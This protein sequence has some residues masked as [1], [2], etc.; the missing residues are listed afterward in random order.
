MDWIKTTWTMAAGLVTAA[1]TVFAQTP[2]PVSPT[3]ALSGLSGARQQMSQQASLP[4]VFAPT[5]PRTTYSRYPWKTEIA[6]TVFWIGEESSANNPTPNNKSS[7]DMNWVQS[8]GGF[9]T[10]DATKRAVNY[11]PLN[12]IPKQNPFYLALP[13]NDVIDSSTTKAEARSRIPWFNQ[14]FTRPGKSVVEGQW[15]A[16]QYG[17]RVCYAQWED[18]GPFVTDDV[19]YVF[20][21]A[22]PKNT[23]NHGAGIDVS[24][25]VRDYL[26]LAMNTKVNWRF[27][28]YN[29]IPDGPWRTFGSNNPF[30]RARANSVNNERNALASRLEELRRMRD[31]AF[32][33]TGNSQYQNR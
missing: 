33:K 4:R 16:I 9:D 29:E 22:R 26:G 3:A 28:D 15:V 30:V 19:E 5:M 27:V 31:E 20:G 17:N 21:N 25:A 24:P 2:A 1:G 18:C 23:Q 8:Y 11:T 13:Y 12:F 10:P 6:A 7:W 32:Q 14:R